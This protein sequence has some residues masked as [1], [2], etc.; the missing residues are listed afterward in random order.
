MSLPPTVAAVTL[1]DCTFPANTGEHVILRSV[2]RGEP[3]SCGAGNATR[4]IEIFE[5]TWAIIKATNELPSSLA[6]NTTTE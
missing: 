6:H 5:G 2:I 1:W 4:R 3:L